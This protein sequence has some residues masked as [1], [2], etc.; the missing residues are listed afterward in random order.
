MDEERSQLAESFQRLGDRREQFAQECLEDLQRRHPHVLDGEVPS[1]A[2]FLGA[3][4]RF[5][6]DDAAP[7]FEPAPPDV[8]DLADTLMKVFAHCLGRAAWKPA[9]ALAW[10]QQ[11]RERGEFLLGELRSE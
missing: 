8:A 4:Q 2:A 7:S 1:P 3:V 6:E 5:V 11:M 10:N 9:M